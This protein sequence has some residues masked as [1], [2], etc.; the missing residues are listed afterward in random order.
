[1]LAWLDVTACAGCI[2]ADDPGLGKTLQV[3]YL[4]AS[5]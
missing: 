1:M 4:I 2:L 3:R 5:N